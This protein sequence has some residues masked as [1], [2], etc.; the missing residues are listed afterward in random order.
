MVTKGINLLFSLLWADSR[1]KY[2]CCN[3]LRR[4]FT[5]YL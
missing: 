1:R 3:W 2:A 5:C 4:L